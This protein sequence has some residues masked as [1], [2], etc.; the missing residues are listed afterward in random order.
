MNEK[1]CPYGFDRLI[2]I[3]SADNWHLRAGIGFEFFGFRI[4]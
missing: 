3:V 4:V 2:L 1:V